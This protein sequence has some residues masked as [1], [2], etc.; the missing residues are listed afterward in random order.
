MLKEANR[1]ENGNKPY[2]LLLD[3]MNLARVEYYFSGLLNVKESRDR[4]NEEMVSAPV[5]EV[6][7]EEGGKLLLRDN[8]YIIGTLIMD[9][10]THPFS[11][12]RSVIMKISLG[13]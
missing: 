9:E 4:K 2:F 10:T 13:K 5:V 8:F 3:E 11:R 7:E 6:K 12:M 1:P